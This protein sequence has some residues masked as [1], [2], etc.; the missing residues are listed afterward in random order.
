MHRISNTQN[1][2]R[3][4]HSKQPFHKHNTLIFLN[5]IF[6]AQVVS[7]QRTNS[8][9]KHTGAWF[10]KAISTVLADLLEQNRKKAHN[11][12]G[13]GIFLAILSIIWHVR[14]FSQGLNVSRRFEMD[15]LTLD[16]VEVAGFFLGEQI[17][18][19]ILSGIRFV[20]KHGTQPAFIT[21]IRKASKDS[22]AKLFRHMFNKYIN[23]ASCT[24]TYNTAKT[25]CLH[26]VRD[27][28]VVLLWPYLLA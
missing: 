12:L 23:D 16:L 17:G 13:A 4:S 10:I 15:W 21:F 9:V 19:G 25:G 5:P 7:W 22:Q 14:R 18:V 8:T 27:V 6:I 1:H 26:T 11:H 3:V 24:E 28:R 20:C 2:L